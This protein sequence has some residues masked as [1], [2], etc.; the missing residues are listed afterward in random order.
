VLQR[1]VDAGVRVFAIWEP[2]LPTDLAP[3]IT[4]V[5]RRMP[6]S[7]VRQYWDPDHLLAQRMAADARQPQPTQ[8]C[9]IRSG[10]LWDL[11]AVYPAGLKWTDRLPTATVFNGPVVD[12]TEAIDAALKK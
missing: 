9:C 5:L 8:D 3:P 7:R 6:D 1:H 11:A 12:V 2:I 4:L 10:L